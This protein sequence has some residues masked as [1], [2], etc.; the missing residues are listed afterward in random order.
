MSPELLEASDALAHGPDA[1]PLALDARS[2]AGRRPTSDVEPFA[3][4]INS[5]RKHVATSS[6]LGEP[7]NN[8]LVMTKPPVE[9]VRDLKEQAGGDIGDLLVG[10]E[11]LAISDIKKPPDSRG[12]HH[13]GKQAPARRQVQFIGII[14]A[15][16]QADEP[17]E[18]AERYGAGIK[19]LAC[20]A[21]HGGGD[22]VAPISVRTL[23]L[24]AS[25]GAVRCRTPMLRVDDTWGLRPA[26]N[27]QRLSLRDRF[28]RAAEL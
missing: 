21:L 27:R 1:R 28:T 12:D 4:F 20:G 25:D 3:S 10:Q 26:S 2:R 8:T 24:S 15:R 6:E 9:Y 7:W 19:R 13:G 22:G 11:G 16:L 17:H 18:L 14:L 5:T 23:Q